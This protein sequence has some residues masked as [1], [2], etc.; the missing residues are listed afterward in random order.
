[1]DPQQS[2]ID[3]S[4]IDANL[5]RS[6][7]VVPALDDDMDGGEIVQDD[8][9][10]P[11]STDDVAPPT[12]KSSLVSSEVVESLLYEAS[13]LHGIAVT[14]HMSTTA[15]ALAHNIGLEPHS[16][17][18]FLAGISYA[19]NSMIVEKLSSII[20]DMQIETRNLQTA[21]SS[22]AAVSNEFLGKMS[23]NKREI[24]D[25]M[26]K[27]R[28]SVLNAVASIQSAELGSHIGDDF[29]N[30]TVNPEGTS[31]RST[32][33][34]PAPVDAGLLSKVLSNPV[35]LKSPDEILYARKYKLLLDLGIEIPKANL[36]PD[37]M[38]TLIPDWQ[39]EA[40]EAGLD[41]KTKMELTDELL[42]IVITLNLI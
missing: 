37:I 26:E 7:Y 18:W 20:K 29:V 3:F 11:R 17:D 25:E 5:H 36:S 42:D 10:V 21:T 28:E 1:M 35:T 34:P 2:A 19:N 23:R 30:L 14:P 24:I 13:V 40:A 9:S 15:I 33:P 32:V 38:N 31:E 41:S 27:T 6:P 4:E 16:L 39:L 12:Q 8:L 22:V